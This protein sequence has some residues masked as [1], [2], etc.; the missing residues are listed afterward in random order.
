MPKGA[1]EKWS[2]S[3]AAS[4]GRRAIA[5]RK[6]RLLNE[7]WLGLVH[8]KLQERFP[9]PELCGFVTKF[10]TRSPN[11]A[12]AVTAAIGGA[13]YETGVLRTLRGASES[14]ARA[15]ADVVAETGF[16]RRAIAVAQ[17][18]WLAGP[19]GVS[20]ALDRRN[21][22]ALDIV[23]PDTLDLERG[24][25]YVDA[26]LWLHGGTWIEVDA[27][28][29]RYYGLDGKLIREV[30]H[31]VGECP[32]VPFVAGETVGDFWQSAAHA[33]LIDGTLEAAVLKAHGTYVQQV[34]ANKLTH[35][36]GKL[37]DMAGLQNIG[38]F[39][40][41]VVSEDGTTINVIDRAVDPAANWGCIART[42]ADAVA[43]YGINPAEVTG[44]IA[45]NSEWGSLYLK[46]RSERMFKLRNKQVEF[47]AASE[48]KLWESVA[49]T[50]R[51][52]THRHSKV[53]PPP[54]EIA[55]MLRLSFASTASNEEVEA[56]FK[57]LEAGLSH[58]LTSASEVLRRLRPELS[59][60]E[61]TE[62]IDANLEEYAARNKFLATHNAPADASTA[63]KPLAEQQGR[64]GGLL[65]G[66]VRSTDSTPQT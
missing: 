20:P 16:N 53:M 13:P 8:Q 57:A 28:A 1:L 52:S 10:A 41:P 35:I 9:N 65:S 33:G 48:R 23:T 66:L 31:S 44:H 6:L 59:P 51:N 18:A 25:E 15:F 14:V 5:S 19:T 2:A 11:L 42:V 39:A 3:W 7:D 38:E 47:V 60:D 37:E 34:S 40:L 61:V 30:P 43:V 50:V 17:R 29:W 46:V 21:R 32:L 56:R 24:G 63:G 58:G 22:V 26:A 55:E 49:A 62:I 12:L 36:D 45:N 64:Q 4:A 54:D 27:M